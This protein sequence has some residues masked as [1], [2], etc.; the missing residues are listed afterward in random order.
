MGRTCEDWILPASDLVIDEVFVP[1]VAEPP[2]PEFEPE[3][4]IW[5]VDAQMCTS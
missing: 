3:D 4:G 2:F 5:E 1:L